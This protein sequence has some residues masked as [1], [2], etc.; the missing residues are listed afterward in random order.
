MEEAA[1]D[2][3]PDTRRQAAPAPALYVG[4]VVH[5]RHRPVRHRLAYGV[6]FLLL[7][8]DEIDACAAQSRL[9]AHNR[10]GVLSFYDRDHGPLDGTPLRPWVERHL[11]EAGLQDP[12]GRIMVACF[13]RLWGYVFNPLSV[14]YC[15]DRDGR[16]TAVLHEVRNTFGELHGYLLPVASDATAGG[17]IRQEVA[18]EFH[19]SPFIPMAARYVFRLHVPDER[20]VLVIEDYFEDG[21]GLTAVMTGTRRPLTD[22]ALLAAV[23]RHPLM[24]LKVIAAIH[25]HALRLWLKGV[26][27]L[28]KPPKPANTVT[29]GPRSR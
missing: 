11:K 20:F 25:W 9:F 27:F 24:T 26:P 18:K 4:R 28:S 12:G 13:P 5:E 19:V 16:L 14:Y 10:F 1:P 29:I 7:D 21:L 8:L 3:T 2:R 23:A 17:A 22:R 6:F 15:F